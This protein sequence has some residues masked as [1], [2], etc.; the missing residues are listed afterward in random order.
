MNLLGGSGGMPP[1]NFKKMHALRLNLVLSKAQNCYAK[2]RLWKSAVRE[3]SLSSR[4]L[5][6]V[7]CFNITI[8][9]EKYGIF[10]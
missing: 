1:E 8:N 6:R 5:N 7:S 9:L 3:I 10:N 2:D 4:H